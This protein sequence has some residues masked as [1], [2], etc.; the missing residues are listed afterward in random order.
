VR[1]IESLSDVQIVL[2]GLLDFQSKI[3][4]SGLDLSGLRA[5]NAGDALLPQDYVTLKQLQDAGV[6]GT[7][8]TNGK[9]GPPGPQG[10]T[11]SAGATGATG[12]AVFTTQ[13]VVT[14]SRVEGTVYHNTGTKPILVVADIFTT[15]SV[16]SIVAYTD[17]SITPTTAVAAATSRGALDHRSVIFC[18]LPGNYYKILNDAG[19][20]TTGVWTEWS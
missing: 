20:P 4:T 13:N 18:V 14:G 7:V 8:G 12:P 10:S 17:S 2:R 1:R 16:G 9:L 3:E 19:T 11:G 6:V 15:A 5:R